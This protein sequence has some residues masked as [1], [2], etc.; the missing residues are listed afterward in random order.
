MV[1]DIIKTQEYVERGWRDHSMMVLTNVADH[2]KLIREMMTDSSNSQRELAVNLALD[3]VWKET[4][5]KNLKSIED[6]IKNIQDELRNRTSRIDTLENDDVVEKV[7]NLRV[8]GIWIALGG[9]LIIV[10]DI[11]FKLW[12]SLFKG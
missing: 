3:S 5:T 12:D 10:V 7:S 11:A 8:K 2:T 1:D 9:V 4:F 6:D